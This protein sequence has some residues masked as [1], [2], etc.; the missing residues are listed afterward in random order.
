M[1]LHLFTV[2]SMPFAENTYVAWRPGQGDAVVIDPGFEP[3]LVLQR[4]RDEGL[5]VRLILNTHGHVDHIAGNAA[6]KDAFPGAP[7]RADWLQLKAQIRNPWFGGEMI[8]CG[9]E[10]KP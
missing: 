10:V 9:S 2:E 5:R 3:D 6:L 7:N 8:D 1:A 4:L